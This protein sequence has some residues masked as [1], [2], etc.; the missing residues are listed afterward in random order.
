MLVT[1]FWRDF[2]LS[3]FVGTVAGGITNAVAVWMLF[4]PYERTF[5]LKGM[6]YD[7][8]KKDWV[9]VAEI[10]KAVP[11]AGDDK[12]PAAAPAKEAPKKGGK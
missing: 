2:A 12:A 8:A 11:A 9:P 6:G 7:V 10:G 5:G 4:H 3:V 1:A